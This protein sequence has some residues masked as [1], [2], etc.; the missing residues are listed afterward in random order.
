VRESPSL[1]GKVVTSIKD[2]EKVTIKDGPK[3]A[4]GHSWYQVE[5]GDKTGWAVKD[6]LE[7][8]P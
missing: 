1:T 2:G 4:D 7:I 5:Y 8:Q 3:D 6:Y